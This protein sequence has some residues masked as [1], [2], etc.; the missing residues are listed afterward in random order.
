M[1]D[2]KDESLELND[3]ELA[4]ARGDDP[5]DVLSKDVSITDASPDVEEETQEEVTEEQASEAEDS[6]EADQ[7]SS[8]E[9]AEGGTDAAD[10]WLDDSMREL[11][12]SYGLSDE[13]LGRFSN[14]D[15]FR[16]AALLFDKRLTPEARQQ[17]PPP[18]TEE[19]QETPEEEP[20]ELSLDPEKYR[21]AGYDDETI[22]I[23]KYAADLRSR[24]DALAQQVEALNKHHQEQEATR[25]IAAFHDAVD[26][27]DEGRYGRSMDKNGRPRTLTKEHDEARHQLWDAAATMRDYLMRQ[28]QQTGGQMPSDKVILQRAEHMAFGEAIAQSQTDRIKK[29]IQAQS[30]KRRPVA[31]A[32]P[33]PKR[34]Q[35]QSSLGEH[36]LAAEYANHPAIVEAW[37]RLTQESGS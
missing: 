11:G 12:R 6:T 14:A 23:V 34:S 36:D 1:D 26:E 22:A 7:E 35:T 18:K 5:N 10:T 31:N 33:A 8:Q 30:R 21:E 19:T 16:R 2:N 20:D 32:R 28:A 3:R 9:E 15:E 17:T 4:I 25:V 29:D 27:L 37:E 13:E 24:H